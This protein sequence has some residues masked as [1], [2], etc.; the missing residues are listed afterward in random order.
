MPSPPR[1]PVPSPSK[2]FPSRE[3]PPVPAYSPAPGGAPLSQRKGGS[4][5]SRSPGG[6]PPSPRGAVGARRLRGGRSPE[7]SVRGLGGAAGAGGSRCGAAGPGGAAAG[8]QRAIHGRGGGSAGE[9]VVASLPLVAAAGRKGGGRGGRGGEWPSVTPAPRCPVPC[10]AVLPPRSSPPGLPQ[11]AA[12]RACGC[13]RLPPGRGPGEAP[14][15]SVVLRDF[16]G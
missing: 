14:P 15:W 1:V 12:S 9:P 2:R 8:A 4:G 10:R 13:R 5:R 7:G 11:N 6:P 3:C 16:V